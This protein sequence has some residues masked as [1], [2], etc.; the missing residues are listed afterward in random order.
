MLVLSSSSLQGLQQAAEVTGDVSCGECSG[1]INRGEG[2]DFDIG[3]IPPWFMVGLYVYFKFMEV[4]S[5]GYPDL[6]VSL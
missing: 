4:Q 1:L 2:E 5:V 6:H 3:L